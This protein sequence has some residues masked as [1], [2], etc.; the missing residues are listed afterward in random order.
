MTHNHDKQPKLGV[1]VGEHFV[2]MDTPPPRVLEAMRRLQA[3]SQRGD[4]PGSGSSGRD[5]QVLLEWLDEQER[6]YPSGLSAE[7]ERDG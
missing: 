1:Q 2:G 5:S 4:R 3:A 6:K 7:E